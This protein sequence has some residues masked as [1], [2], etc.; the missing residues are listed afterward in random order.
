[1]QRRFQDRLGDREP[2]QRADGEDPAD[3]GAERSS[4]VAADASADH[5]ALA[6]EGL[7][8]VSLQFGGREVG[9]AL[10]PQLAAAVERADHRL[11]LLQLRESGLDGARQVP[12]VGAEVKLDQR[13]RAFEAALLIEREAAA[14]IAARG[15]ARLWI[16][17][18]NGQRAARCLRQSSI[19]A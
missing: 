11:G 1:L 18:T 12:A 7:G 15:A 10:F 17:L 14:D 9:L 16:T 3:H 6:L 13:L 4:A 2:D 5:G 8:E 19:R